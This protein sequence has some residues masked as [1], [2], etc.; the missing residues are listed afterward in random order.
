[1]AAI[2]ATTR[3][4]PAIF[5]TMDLNG[6][7]YFTEQKCKNRIYSKYISVDGEKTGRDGI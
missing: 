2:A 4:I 3:I 5:F 7:Y 1:M 6:S